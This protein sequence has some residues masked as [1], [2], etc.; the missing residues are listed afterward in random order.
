MEA[1]LW[2]PLPSRPAR[3][4]AP[5]ARPAGF[6]PSCCRARNPAGVLLVPGSMNESW[7]FL[8]RSGC[9]LV[10]LLLMAG[11][12][13]WPAHAEIEALWEAASRGDTAAVRRLL[14]E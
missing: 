8:M 3:P 7:R 13:A 12:T 6:P 2:G 1:P 9:W 14:E 4:W 10:L 5:A 11:G